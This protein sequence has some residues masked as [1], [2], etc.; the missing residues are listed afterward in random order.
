MVKQLL[1]KLI[2]W[3]LKLPLSCQNKLHSSKF[4]DVKNTERMS[5]SKEMVCFKSYLTIGFDEAFEIACKLCREKNLTFIHAFNDPWIVSGQ[6]TLGLEILHQNPYIDTIIS[7]IGGGGLISG[8][9]LAVKSIN[10]KIK[11]YGVETQS[12]PKMASSIKTGAISP[13][14]YFESIADG[15][16]VK[17]TGQVTYDIVKEYVDDFAGVDESEISFAV[18]KLLEV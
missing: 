4:K 5:L 3:E 16:T 10:P 9:A 17:S 15:I 13:V 1:T 7:P 2:K 6:G 14:P 18:L 12:M 11:I 8:T